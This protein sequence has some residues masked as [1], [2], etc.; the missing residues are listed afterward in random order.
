MTLPCFTRCELETNLDK[1]IHWS[2]V[3]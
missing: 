2:T 3:I 1:Y